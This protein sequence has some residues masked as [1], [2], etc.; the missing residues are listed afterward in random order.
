[1]A[2]PDVIPVLQVVRQLVGQALRQQRAQRRQVGEARG[3]LR[4]GRRPETGQHGLNVGDLGEGVLHAAELARV[5]QAVLEPAEDA[6]NVTHAVEQFAQLSQVC[7]RGNHLAHDGLPALDLRQVEGGGG[8]P[9]LEQ[10]G[11]GGGRAAV[12]GAEQRGLARAAGGLEDLQVPQ[13]GRVEEQGAGAAVFLQRTE[14]LRLGAEVFRGVVHDRAGGAERR[15]RVGEAET[16]EVEHAERVHHGPG[17]AGDLEMIARQLGTEPRRTELVQGVDLMLLVRGRLPFGEVALDEHHLGRIERREHR[18]QVAGV[19]IAR[20]AEF[21]GRQVEPRGVQAGLVEGE[22]TE[23]VVLRGVELVG[24]EGRAGREDARELAFHELA[25]LGGLGLVADGDLL[26]G[27]EELA[28]VVVGRV[29]GDARHRGRLAPGE[30]DAQQARADL[31]VLEEHLVE[32]AEPEEQER[33]R[34]EAA[35]DLEVL[36]HHRR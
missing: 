29:V 18:Q 35:L 4:D 5:A 25:G 15:M 9:A 6:G 1:M 16:L 27:G 12:D 20:D 10:A 26:A 24:G 34:R 2:G 3:H 13:R 30:G 17:A 32:I 22:G 23:V 36:D 21:A 14:V 28:D 33:V 11:A 19:G 7:R 31:G 8:E